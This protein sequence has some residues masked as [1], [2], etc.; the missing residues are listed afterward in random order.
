MSR[1][2]SSS[3]VRLVNSLSLHHSSH[4]MLSLIGDLIEQHPVL[5][6]TLVFAGV[7]MLIPE[8][9]ILRPLLRMVGF[10]PDGPVKGRQPICDYMLSG[11][12]T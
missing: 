5:I 8:S 4:L 1:S 6:S 12:L 9:W 10:G 11:L 3:Q 7:A 2:W